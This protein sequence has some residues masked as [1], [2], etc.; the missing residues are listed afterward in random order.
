VRPHRRYKAIVVSSN[1][2]HPSRTI[3][4]GV[5]RTDN[6]PVEWFNLTLSEADALATDL[7]AARMGLSMSMARDAAQPTKGLS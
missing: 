4:I 6:S 1:Y 2:D 5:R 3:G 7:N